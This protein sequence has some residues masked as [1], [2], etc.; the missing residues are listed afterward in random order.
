[1][2]QSYTSL[3]HK[4][5]IS[6]PHQAHSAYSPLSIER[7]ER[8]VLD[9]QSEDYLIRYMI[10]GEEMIR[11]GYLRHHLQEGSFLL[12]NPNKALHI[13]P[14]SA[15]GAQSITIRIPVELM[16]QVGSQ[17]GKNGGRASH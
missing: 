16:R 3:R 8:Q 2:I 9:F 10:S 4:Q 5:H 1:M 14:L 11:Q 7:V 6:P 12:V 17:D 15:Q 13:R